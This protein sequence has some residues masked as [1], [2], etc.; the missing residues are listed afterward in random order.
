M[1]LSS[2]FLL[3]ESSANLITVEEEMYSDLNT[4][5]HFAIEGWTHCT[6]FLSYQP[7]IT[8]TESNNTVISG[9][10]PPGA[11]EHHAHILT[12]VQMMTRA[13]ISLALVI[14]LPLLL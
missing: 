9:L 3:L 2:Y 1:V 4:H 7:S 11:P 12:P 6:L 13:H 10:S 8:R 5:L 14:D